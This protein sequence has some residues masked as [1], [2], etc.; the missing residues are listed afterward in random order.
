[1][2]TNFDKALYEAPMG[3]DNLPEEEI[4]VEIEN[5]E[6]VTIAT[7]DVEITGMDAKFEKASDE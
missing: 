6:S 2:A 5:P 3:M 4:E 7:G 1:M